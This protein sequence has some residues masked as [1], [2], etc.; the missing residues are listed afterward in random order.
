MWIT[1]LS[2][3][4]T[5]SGSLVLLDWLTSGRMA[6]GEEWC[7][8]RYKS[9]NEVHIGTERVARDVLLLAQTGSSASPPSCTSPPA[10]PP[11]TL[12]PRTIADRLAPYAC[13]TIVLLFGPAATPLAAHFGSVPVNGRRKCPRARRR[14][15]CGVSAHLQ[16]GGGAS[17]ALR[18][19][20]RIERGR[21]SK[22][23]SGDLKCGLGRVRQGFCVMSKQ[24]DV[25]LIHNKL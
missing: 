5:D 20:K 15:S 2:F 6:I 3:P 11:R 24:V 16:K 7:F 17:C 13:Y 22:N 8:T 18:E 9:T 25:W 4:G 21:G 23:S 14:T 12:R 1:N 10:A 19:Q